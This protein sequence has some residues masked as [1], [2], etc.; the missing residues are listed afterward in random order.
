MLDRDRCDLDEKI[1]EALAFRFDLFPRL[2]HGNG[3]DFRGL[4]LIAKQA[5][6]AALIWYT[7]WVVLWIKTP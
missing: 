5:F 7:G 6:P 2:H 4:A 3:R 1:L